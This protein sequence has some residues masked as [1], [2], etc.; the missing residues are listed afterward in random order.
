MKSF[1]T[2]VRRRPAAAQQAKGKGEKGKPGKGKG[3]RANPEPTPEWV[4]PAPVPQVAF[5][6]SDMT[7]V[8]GEVPTTDRMKRARREH[9]S[10]YAKRIF[11]ANA[12]EALPAC[13]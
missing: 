8:E 9:L 7:A 10:D 13:L 2:E 11:T 3:K 4:V 1:A 12:E 5:G 6:R